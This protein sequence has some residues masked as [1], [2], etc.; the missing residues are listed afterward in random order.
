MV[1][2]SRDDWLQ[3]REVRMRFGVVDRVRDKEDREDVRVYE[4]YRRW[5]CEMR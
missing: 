3:S 5:G 1:K 2:S 4:E